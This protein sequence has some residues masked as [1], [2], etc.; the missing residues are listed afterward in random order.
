MAKKI[1]TV[2]EFINIKKEQFENEKKELDE[3]MKNKKRIPKRLLMAMKD[4]G[5]KTEM[6]FIREAWSFVEQSNLN[7]KV[8][9]VER[10][11]KYKS[12]KSKMSYGSSWKEGDIEYRISYWIVGQIR[13]RKNKWTFG[14]FCPII[15][16]N[17]LEKV[18]K[19]VEDLSYSDNAKSRQNKKK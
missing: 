9:V 13:N 17:D 6:F 12:D 8:F 18:I 7:K 5:R 3:K 10:L 2:Q 1:E 15:P 19:A 16:E 4:I 11:K 14:A